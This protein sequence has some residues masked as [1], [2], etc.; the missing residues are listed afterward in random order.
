LDNLLNVCGQKL[1]NAVG[2]KES[3]AL[4]F[5]S[6]TQ[7]DALDLSSLNE[8]IKKASGQAIDG[9]RLVVVDE[10]RLAYRCLTDAVCVVGCHT[11]TRH[12]RIKKLPAVTLAI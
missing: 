12:C 1:A 5:V 10:F 11:T 9:S 6:L 8:L 7:G 2:N 3:L 4:Y